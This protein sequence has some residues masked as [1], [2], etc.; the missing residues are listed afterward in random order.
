MVV[1][2]LN[3][4]IFPWDLFLVAANHIARAGLHHFQYVLRR[5]NRL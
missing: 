4:S 1:V 5:K 2:G 3:D